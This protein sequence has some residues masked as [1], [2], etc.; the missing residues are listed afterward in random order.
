MSESSNTNTDYQPWIPTDRQ[1]LIIHMIGIG[2]ITVF[3]GFL[4][5]ATVASVFA[6]LAKNA[7]VWL[8]A[9]IIFSLVLLVLGFGF[10]RLPRPIDPGKNHETTEVWHARD[11]EE[12]SQFCASL[13]ADLDPRWRPATEMYPSSWASI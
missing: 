4:A 5:W 10:K 1:M 9:T 3:V 12:G 13:Q 2:V 7:A 6:G 8:A 11:W